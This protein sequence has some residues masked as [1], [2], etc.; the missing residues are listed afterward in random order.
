MRRLLSVFLL[1]PFLN[2][3]QEVQNVRVVRDDAQIT[4]LLEELGTHELKLDIIDLLAFP[5]L[6]VTY[7]IISDPYSSY[8]INTYLNLSDMGTADGWIDRFSLTPFYRF[9]FFNKTDFGGAGFFAELF[10]RL[11]FGKNEE[12]YYYEYNPDMSLMPSPNIEADNF[13]DFALGASIGKKW[14]NKKGWTFELMFGLGRF[15]F[16][17]SSDSNGYR[18]DVAVRGGVALGKRF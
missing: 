9:Y 14:V 8:G 12:I 15:L 10:G 17:N 3:A 16:N 6:D 11:T 4:E 7:E 13:T 1:I 5:A 18:S 2:L